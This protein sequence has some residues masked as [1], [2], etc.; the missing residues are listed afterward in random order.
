MKMIDYHRP[1]PAAGGNPSLRLRPRWPMV[2]GVVATATGVALNWNWLAAAGLA[3]FL[4][5][6]LPCAA[7]CA[8]GLCMKVQ[9]PA[10][11]GVGEDTR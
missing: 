6:A 5:G 11:T 4:L 8:L 9:S 3:P 1:A 7:L 10:Q 2:A